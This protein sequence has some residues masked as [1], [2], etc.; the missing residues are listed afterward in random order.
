[1][2]LKSS[3][4]TASPLTRNGIPIDARL[5][6]LALGVL[7]NRAGTGALTATFAL[8]LTRV[9]GF[10]PSHV[11]LAMSFAAGTSMLLQVPI[12][13]WG[14]V[15]G[16]RE[17]MALLT[18]ASGAA[19]ILL[20]FTRNVWYLSLV[21]AVVVTLQRGSASVRDGYVARLAL[22]P[23]GVAFKAYLRAVTN[24]AMSLG[25]ALGA[26]ALWVDRPEA[27]LLVLAMDGLTSMIAG[28]ISLRLPHVERTILSPGLPRLAVLRDV[29]YVSITF[30]IGVV[31]IHFV[32]MEVGVPLWIA[33]HTAAP[34][35]L[36][37]LLL[38]LNTLVVAVLQVRLVRGIVTIAQS[39]RAMLVGSGCIAVAFVAVA[40]SSWFGAVGATLLLVLGTASHVLE[41]MRSSGGQWG[42]QMGLAPAER[43]GQYQGFAGLSLSFPQTV[44]PALVT[45]LCIEWGWQGWLVLAAVVLGSSL[46]LPVATAWAERTRRQYGAASHSGYGAPT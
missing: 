45:L 10:A 24:L 1:M 23:S 15:R 32:V 40:L 31:S 41:E 46:L 5:R 30:L 16:A 43:Q 4:S 28:L 21:L 35:P 38:G 7:I 9:L 20:I 19:G 34:K 11:G 13:H 8:Y 42:I 17:V 2:L 27:Y 3:S 6:T 14:D 39:A 26:V 36:A 33:Q 12:G 29:P 25:A 22:G 44:A 18:A 37:A